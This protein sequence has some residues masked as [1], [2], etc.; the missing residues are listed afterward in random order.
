MTTQELINRIDVRTTTSYGHYR[1][2]I[3]YRGKQYSCTTNNSLAIDKHDDE[4]ASGIYTQKS[5]LLTLWNEC[6]RKNNLY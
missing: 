3:Q 5:A 1:I 2:T 4:Y 6:K